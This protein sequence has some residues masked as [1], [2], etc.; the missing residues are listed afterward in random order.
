MDLLTTAEVA[1]LLRVPAGT[2]RYWRS[3][4]RGPRSSRLGRKVVYTR[5]DVD[6]WIR[7]EMARTTRGGT[8]AQRGVA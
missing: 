6:A 1:D 3:I 7:E 4:G 8:D 2:A 5:A